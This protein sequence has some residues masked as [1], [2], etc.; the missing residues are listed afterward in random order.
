MTGPDTLSEDVQD[1]LE[2]CCD[3]GNEALDEGEFREAV[4][5][6]EQALKMLPSPAEEW[7][8]Y[9]WLQGALGDAYYGMR[10]FGRALDYFHTA[11]MFAGPDEVPPF[12]LLR[13][14]QCHRRLGD[15]KNAAECLLRAY[16]LEGEDIF[17]DKDDFAFLKEAVPL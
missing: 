10:D 16:L 11:H 6:F 17:E 13:L 1:A 5:F 14:G 9:G 8:P 15:A 2:E 12:V 7:E 3:Q 4:A